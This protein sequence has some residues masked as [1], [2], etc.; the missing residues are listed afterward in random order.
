MQFSNE[1]I[2][3]KE[4]IHELGKYCTLQAMDQVLRN[5]GQKTVV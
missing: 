1:V 3:S 5:L 4:I 2:Y